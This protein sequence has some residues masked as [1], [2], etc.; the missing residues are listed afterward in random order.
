[1]RAGRGALDEVD[2]AVGLMQV[3]GEFEIE[4]HEVRDV[5][6]VDDVVCHNDDQ[7][8]LMFFQELIKD[9]YN[10]VA[11]VAVGFTA[12]VGVLRGVGEKPVAFFGVFRLDGFPVHPFPLADGALLD[13]FQRFDFQLMVSGN[14]T[15]GLACPEHCAAIDPFDRVGAEEFRDGSRLLFAVGAQGKVDRAALQD[16]GLLF[17]GRGGA[18]SDEEEDRGIGSRL[19]GLRSK[20]SGWRTSPL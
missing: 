4:L 14:L 15:G 10:P 7:F 20:K 18:V 8:S 11:D 5:D 6:A 12:E 1:M 2:A 19:H 9:R 16:V 3:F 13:S 17:V